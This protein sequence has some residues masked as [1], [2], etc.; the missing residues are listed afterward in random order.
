MCGDGIIQEGEECDDE[1]ESDPPPALNGGPNR[2]FPNFDFLAN[3]PLP[4]EK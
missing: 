1:N 3:S 4:D 2:R